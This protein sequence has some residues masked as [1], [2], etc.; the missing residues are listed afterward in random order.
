[1]V[2]I[3]RNIEDN[4]CVCEL[5]REK[6]FSMIDKSFL[7][8][9]LTSHYENLRQEEEL[10]QAALE[11]EVE[12]QQAAR[13]AEA[14]RQQAAREA[15]AERRHTEAVKRKKIIK[16][17]AI[18]GIPIIVVVIAFFIVFNMVF[19]PYSNYNKAGRLLANGEYDV[20]FS[21]Y[22]KLGN[23]KDSQEMA[24]AATHQIISEKGY[25]DALPYLQEA[26]K[27]PT[28]QAATETIYTEALS[29]YNTDYMNTAYKWFNTIS[30]YKDAQKYLKLLA[31]LSEENDFLKMKQLNDLIANELKDFKPAE[32]NFNLAL[33]KQ[34]SEFFLTYTGIYRNNDDF[35]DS[36]GGK[37]AHF[38][39][40]SGHKIYAVYQVYDSQDN[41][42]IPRSRLLQGVLAEFAGV[43]GNA[44]LYR[45]TAASFIFSINFSS[46]TIN[47]TESTNQYFP[48]GSYTK[49]E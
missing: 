39:L 15:E 19:V 37:V 13:E 48:N 21:T 14:K 30:N 5:Q 12:R 1:M 35:I 36:N 47:I 28:K 33:Y 4:C 44:F 3:N 18:I 25:N 10:E 32:D 26:L 16:K 20:A 6:A 34:I 41:I 40:I 49:V 31:A 11:A 45:G 22:I 43:D 17:T 2:L 9:K 46:G 29:L 38:I 8:E 23:Y 42:N 27:G 24:I 7:E